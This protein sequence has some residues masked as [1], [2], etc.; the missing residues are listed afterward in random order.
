MQA[1][2]AARDRIED[3]IDD[4]DR[5][6]ALGRRAAAGR[7]PGLTDHVTGLH[8]GSA[9]TTPARARADTTAG[10]PPHP[11]GQCRPMTTVTTTDPSDSC[12]QRVTAAPF[13]AATD[14]P[15]RPSTSAP[16]P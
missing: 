6:R 3:R 1:E 5:P 13:A 9:S 11:G 2:F 16:L 15:A 12:T 7:P 14:A 8:G 10:R 4:G